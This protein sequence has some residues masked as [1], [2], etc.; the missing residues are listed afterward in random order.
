M[1]RRP[2]TKKYRTCELRAVGGGGGGCYGRGVTGPNL[3]HNWV[4]DVA[5]GERVRVRSRVVQFQFLAQ[6]GMAP[7]RFR[8][9]LAENE[10]AAMAALSAEK[11]GRA[12]QPAWPGAKTA[13][14]AGQEL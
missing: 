1:V 2:A 14:P 3:P 6:K 11:E 12:R 13:R 7:S 10:A 8:A 4:S 5:P 9:L